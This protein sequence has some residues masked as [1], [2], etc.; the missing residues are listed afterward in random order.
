MASTKPSNLK[1]LSRAWWKYMQDSKLTKP[2]VDDMK[3]FLLSKGF[4][5]NDIKAAIA[6][7]NIDREPVKSSD[8]TETLPTEKVEILNRIKNLIR[9]KTT[10]KQRVDLRRYLE[11]E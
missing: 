1:D 9:T 3:E 2:T 11:N 5:L 4:S 10:K 8:A 6:S 7:A